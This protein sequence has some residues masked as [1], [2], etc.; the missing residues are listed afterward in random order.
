MRFGKE[1]ETREVCVFVPC[2]AGKIGAMTT[3]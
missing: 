1:E 2:P 3:L